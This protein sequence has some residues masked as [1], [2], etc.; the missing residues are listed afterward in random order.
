MSPSALGA[1][2]PICPTVGDAAQ[3]GGTGLMQSAASWQVTVVSAA[4]LRRAALAGG[5]G[6]VTVSCEGRGEPVDM[7]LNWCPV[8]I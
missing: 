3:A 5:E 6:Y 4:V 1:S 2:A 7:T 8:E